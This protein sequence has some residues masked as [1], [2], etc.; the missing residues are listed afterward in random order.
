MSIYTRVS[1]QECTC[2]HKAREHGSRS[3]FQFLALQ[4]TER[5]R[6]SEGEGERGERAI[7]RGCFRLQALRQTALY[8][9]QRATHDN[10]NLT[11]KCL[12]WEQ[13]RDGNSTGPTL[14]CFSLLHQQPDAHR[15]KGHLKFFSSVEE[16]FFNLFFWWKGVCVEVGSWKKSQ[17]AR[18]RSRDWC[19]LCAFAVAIVTLRDSEDSSSRYCCWRWP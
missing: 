13:S 3:A 10:R 1:P 17:T 2:V 14:K 9:E 6:E 4:W 18:D 12:S 16:G 8:Y 15:R 11:R 5:E 19:C 7:L